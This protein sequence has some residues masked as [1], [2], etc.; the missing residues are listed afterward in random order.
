[1]HAGN[2][3]D[4][5]VAATIF[6]RNIDGSITSYSNIGELE[7]LKLRIYEKTGIPPGYQQ[8]YF[9]R[10]LLTDEMIR[11]IPSGS[12]VCLFIGLKGG[13]FNCEICYEVGEYQCNVCEKKIF[14]SDCCRKFHKHPS[15]TNHNPT[16]LCSDEP[17]SQTSSDNSDHNC[18]RQNKYTGDDIDDDFSGNKSDEFVISDSPNSSNIFQEASMI[19]TLAESFNLTRFRDYQKDAILALLSGRDCLIAHPT[20]SGKSLC[21]KFPAVYENKKSLV[22]TP[23]ISLM[24][25]QVKN[26][27]EQHIKASYLGSAQLDLNMEDKFLSI[28]SDTN[29]I[30][31]TPEWIAKPDKRAKVQ[32]LA[33][34]KQ[35]S[36]IAI[37]EAHLYHYW[38]EFRVAYKELESLKN[39]FPSIPI[40]CLTATAP[41]SVEESILKLLR[42]PMITKGSINR[43]NI[44]L[45]CEV[46]PSSVHRKDFSY[47]ASRVSDLLNDSDS[48]I[49][50]TDFIDDVGPIMNKLSDEGIESCAYY[51]EM[52]VKSRNESYTRWRSGEIKVMVATSAFGMGINKPDIRHII[53]F[54]VPE[55]L[56]SWAQELGRAGRDGHP[57]KATIFYANS[58]TEHAGAWIKGKI[59]DSTTCQRILNEFS[60]SWKYVTSDLVCKCRRVLLLESFGEECSETEAEAD[61]CCDV[62]SNEQVKTDI[63]FTEELKTLYNAIEVIG[64]KG[65]VKIAQWVRGSTLSWTDKYNKQSVSYGKSHGHNEEWWRLFIRKCH[66]LGTANKQLKSIIKQSQHYSVQGVICTTSKGSNLIQNGEKFT[67]PPMMSEEDNTGNQHKPRSASKK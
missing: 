57:A 43:P 16:I 27:E 36:M 65:E 37:D 52:D 22:I 33:E 8:L 12:N 31:V 26:C 30:F 56:C 20:G 7:Q 40:A 44:T 39:E 54:G 18:F 59:S 41:P 62:C 38:Q 19:A 46:I 63:D 32:A 60:E 23:T 4:P 55:N 58:H 21:F 64:S 53:R 24:Q 10:T 51:G 50:Y 28:L 47:F 61:S 35:L 49:I 13:G 25:D 11:N 17:S 1:M 15:R 2:E 14:C 42:N 3:E 45:S 67:I 6:V 29:L 66:V 9:G 34:H 48:A 5:N